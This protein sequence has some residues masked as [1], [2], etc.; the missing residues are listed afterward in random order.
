MAYVYGLSCS[1]DRVCVMTI[2]SQIPGESSDDE[3]V[4]NCDLVGMAAGETSEYVRRFG[5][6]I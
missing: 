1:S 4:V 6:D 3:E 2:A 5:L